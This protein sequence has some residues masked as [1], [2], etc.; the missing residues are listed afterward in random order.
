[1]TTHHHGSIASLHHELMALLSAF[2]YEVDHNAGTSASTYFTEDARLRFEEASFRGTAEID[3]VYRGRAARG[4]R[5]SR[6]LVTNL[7]LLD[8]ER[9]TVR[10]LSA[11][12]LF[13]EDGEAPRPSTSPTLVA[14]VWDEFERVDGRWLIS[15]RWIRNLFLESSSDLAVPVE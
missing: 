15:S 7:H 2:W 9:T 11:L 8:V 4:P 6:H 3:A 12:L 13:A 5:V 14:D 1:M 10:A